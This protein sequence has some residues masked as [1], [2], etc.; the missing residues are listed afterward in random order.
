MGKESETF[1][2]AV[3]WMLGLLSDVSNKCQLNVYCV[4]DIIF[5]AMH[6]EVNRFCLREV[7]FLLDRDSK[8]SDYFSEY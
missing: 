8:L 4:P 3:K 5:C 7:Y 1:K 6:T 2:V